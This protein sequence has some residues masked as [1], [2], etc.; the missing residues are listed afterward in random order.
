MRRLWRFPVPVLEGARV[1]DGPGRLPHNIVGWVV[2]VESS[3]EGW[4]GTIDF[5][6]SF[7]KEVVGRKWRAIAVA[8]REIE[9]EIEREPPVVVRP[10]P[11][12]RLPWRGRRR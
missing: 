7:S 2:A 4:R 11:K 3:A 5:V 9:I 1:Y 12:R 10:K 6:D 8:P